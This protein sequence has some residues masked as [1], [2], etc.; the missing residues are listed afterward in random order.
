MSI[1]LNEP[2]EWISSTPDVDQHDRQCRTEKDDIHKESHDDHQ[3][4]T[5]EKHEEKICSSATEGTFFQMTTVTIS[6][7]KI[8]EK[9]K[10]D[11]SIET[12]TG[13]QSPQLWERERNDCSTRS[14][15]VFDCLLEIF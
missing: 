4:T 6:K 15:T 10:S 5:E 2:N 1:F 11:A 12:K 3:S 8:E 9:V 7:Q 13:D 14:S